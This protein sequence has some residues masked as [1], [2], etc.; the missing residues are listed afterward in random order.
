[1]CQIQRFLYFFINPKSDLKY[2]RRF[3][4]THFLS[5]ANKN[6]FITFK[7][8]I[9]SQISKTINPICHSNWVTA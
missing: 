6:N 5:P 4:S 7:I 8:Q 3:L 2:N 1:M 9:H